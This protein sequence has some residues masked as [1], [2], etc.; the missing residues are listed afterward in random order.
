MT[1]SNQHPFDPS[2]VQAPPAVRR[3]SLLLIEPYF[4]M[5]RTVA[6]VASGLQGIKVHEAPSVES[7]S[8]LLSG[9]AFDGFVVALEDQE[10]VLS[11][12][13][14]IRSGET[15]SPASASVAVTAEH[16]DVA[17]IA[18][19]RELGVRRILVKPFKVKTILETVAA[20]SEQA[21]P[22]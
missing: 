5:R 8:A 21:E 22:G 17:T 3:Y 4:V 20:F 6:S 9:R 19:L 1:A 10:A 7:A 2:Q 16:C 14:S 18:A 11:L 12:I 15:L 13:N